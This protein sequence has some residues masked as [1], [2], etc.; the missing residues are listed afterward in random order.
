MTKTADRAGLGTFLIA[1]ALTIAVIGT[2]IIVHEES[3]QLKDLLN[4]LTG[5][6]W[7]TKSVLSVILFAVAVL[8]LRRLFR[9]VRMVQLAR[10]DNVWLWT[11]LTVVV[12]TL[13]TAGAIGLYI[14]HYLTP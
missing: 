6:H 1:A 4:L 11:M 8:L 3:G 10:A 5:H 13:M 2:M 7:L 9:N 12:T 14:V